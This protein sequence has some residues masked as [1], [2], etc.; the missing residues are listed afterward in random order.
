[1]SLELE[2]RRKYAS[3]VVGL[4]GGI[5][6]PTEKPHRLRPGH[7]NVLHQQCLQ[8]K[9]LGIHGAFQE[10]NHIADHLDDVQD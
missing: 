1:M 8:V 9:Y 3:V 6:V 4:W 7:H 2:R 10:R 5:Q